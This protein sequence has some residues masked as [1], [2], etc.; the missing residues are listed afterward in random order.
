[1]ASGYFASTAAV[2]FSN[3]SPVSSSSSSRTGLPGSAELLVDVPGEP[4]ESSAAL[5][6]RTL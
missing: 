5:A 4:D 6:G 1:V 2:T 3:A